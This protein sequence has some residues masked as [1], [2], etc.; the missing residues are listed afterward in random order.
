MIMIEEKVR[1]IAIVGMALRVPRANT[2]DEFWT[3]IV[4]G[5]DCLSRPDVGQQERAGTPGSQITDSA[6]VASKPL[7]DRMETFDA[8][9][10][11]ISEMEAKIMDP[12]HRL[13][14][15]CVW[16]AMEQS[17]VVPGDVEERTGVFASVES[18]YYPSNLA[19]KEDEIPA[20]R[21]PKRLGNVNDYIAL[22][23]SHALD[24]KGPSVTVL[25]TC[26][27]SL[28]AVN[29]AA[30][31]LRAGKCTT[32]LAGGA[33][34]E[35][36][37]RAGYRSGLDGMISVSGVIRPFDADADGMI[38]GDGAGVV[39][40]KMLDAAIRDGN[41]IQAVIRGT[42]FCNDGQP[43]DKLSFIAPTTSGQKRAIEEALNESAVDPSTIG[44]MECHGTATRLGD[45]V[46]IAS[47][48][49]VFAERT[50]DKGICAL[51]S[52]KANIGHLGPAAGV[53]SLI[54]TCLV[55]SKRVIPPLAN[56]RALNPN[57]RLED[58]PF[59]VPESATQW[60]GEG[61]PHR[62][63]VSAF[64]F[65]GSNAHVVVE[66]FLPSSHT[67]SSYSNAQEL[68]IVSAKTE[69]AFQRRLND[70]AIFCEQE[71]ETPTADF[72]H[73]LQV[74]RQT[75]AFRTHLAVDSETVG[76]LSDRLR[77]AKPTGTNVKQSRPVVFLFPGQGSQTVGMGQG[78]YENES[79]FRELFDYCADV[80]ARKLGFDLRNC[81]YRRNGI[82]EQDAKAALTDTSIAQPALFVVEYALARQLEHWGLVPTTMIGH[83][84]GELVSACLAGVFSLDEGLQLVAIRSRLMQKC[85]PGSMLAVSLP[86]DDLLEI[87]PEELDLAAVNSTKRNVVAGPVDEIEKFAAVLKSKKIISQ[88]LNTSH[89]FHSRMLDETLEEFRH[90]LQDFEFHP[91][92]KLT[93]SGV[94]GSPMTDEQAQDPNYWIEQRRQ[95]VRFSD[96]LNLFLNDDNPI[97]VEVGPGRTLSGFV[98]QNDSSHDTITCL[99]RSRQDS[100]SDAHLIALDSVGRAWSMGANIQWRKRSEEYPVSKLNLPTYPFQRYHYWQDVS[101]PKEASDHKYSLS[102]YEPGWVSKDLEKKSP[103]ELTSEWLIF[104]DDHGFA[105]E[106][107]VRLKDTGAHVTVVEVGDQFLKLSDGVYEILPGSKEDLFQVLSTIQLQDEEARLGVL[108]FWNMTGENVPESDVV[109]YQAAKMKG[110]HTLIALMQVARECHLLNRLDV[111]IYVDGLAQVDPSKDPIYPEKGVLLGPVRVST[112]EVTGLSIR[113][114]DI[115]GNPYEFSDSSLFDDIFREIRVDAEEPVV[116]LRHGGRYAEHLFELPQI[117]QCAPRFRYGGTAL[118]T[119]GVGGLGLKVAEELFQSMNARLVLTSR[120]VPPAPD[121]WTDYLDAESKIGRAM[122]VLCPL[123]EQGAEII[124]LKADASSPEDMER[125]VA[126]AEAEFGPI[127][128]VVHTAGILEDGPSLQK[129][130]Q[131]AERVFAAKVGSAYVID[132]IFADKPLDMLIHFSSQASLRPSKG[133]VDYCSANSVLDRLATRRQQQHPGLSCAVGWGAWRDAGMAWEYKAGDLS[134]TSLFRKKDLAEL[135]PE[136]HSTSHPLLESYRVF[137]DGDVLFS[138]SLVKGE[139]WIT[140]EHQIGGR[141]VVS[142]TTI[143]EMVRAGFVDFF[144]PSGAIELLDVTFVTQFA[145]DDVTDYELLFSREGDGYQVELRTRLNGEGPDWHVTSTAT[146]RETEDD[147]SLD[148]MIQKQLTQ[149]RDKQSLN[150]DDPALKRHGPRWNCGS[151]AVETEDGVAIKNV[152]SPEFAEEVVNYGLH[153]SIFDRSIHKLTEH[154]HGVLLPYSC[155]RIR[156]YAPMPAQ[157]LSFGYLRDSEHGHTHDLF[158]TD[159]DGNLIVELRT[160]MMRDIFHTAAGTED[161]LEYGPTIDH[162]MVLKTPG[163]FDSFEITALEQAPLAADEIRIQVKAAGLN[164]RDVLSALGQLPEDDPTHDMRGSECSGIVTEVG[165]AVKHL[166]TGDRVLALGKHCFSTNVVTAGHMA[167]LLPESLSFTDGA[168]IPVTFLTVDYALNEAARLKS[169]EKILIHAASGG[170]GLAAV[171]MAQHIGAEIFATAGHDFKREYLQDLGVE[172]VLDSRSLD[173]VDR[174]N[175]LTGGK[176]VDVVLNSLAGEFIPAG[177]SLLKPFGRFIELGKKDIYANAKMDLYPFRNNLSYFGID[178]GQ[179][180]THRPD[181]HLQM[182]ESLMQRFAAGQLCPSPVQVFSFDDL[183]KGFK[184]LARTQ[185]IGKVVFNIDQAMT[186]KDIAIQRFT[187]RFGTGIA[188]LD[189]I[190]VLRRLISSDE[191]PAQVLAAA[192]TLD[193]Q[194]RTAR[195]LVSANHPR[196]VETVYREPET[197]TEELLKNIFE[198]TLGI[199]PIGVDDEFIELGGDSITAVML[200]VSL[201]DTFDVHLP[202][203]ALLNQSTI[204]ILGKL[205]DDTLVPASA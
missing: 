141:S 71:P 192:R 171:Q 92:R 169:G 123:V 113:C 108:H 178:L 151:V 39:V 120:W 181:D 184:Y 205:V 139:H 8:R 79:V 191:T 105:D 43:N 82:S 152:L 172:H 117:A 68:L 69:S 190:K 78:L 27:S 72:A 10:F 95:P 160:Y 157:T 94:T 165:S 162:R 21:V 116:A 1:D 98:N 136:K 62:A 7:I 2:L 166:R 173:F 97:F 118:I 5:R 36:P 167:T 203:S 13:F 17:A 147:R 155:D 185:H 70:L 183:G 90:E 189:G 75:M 38:F 135:G 121:K 100:V 187:S 25:A 84:L 26:S 64:G 106:I 34:V 154:Y 127:H 41:Q 197:I 47:L 42:G 156:I 87:I 103:R 179:F 46:E 55:L 202:L 180:R 158:V 54:K 201:K 110:F 142:A 65:G 115:P 83:S 66:E 126:D 67:T 29:L 57:L 6:F 37:R 149:V 59:Y 146:I 129:T 193:T 14:L 137:P 45:P 44:F 186:P 144:S 12:T 128:G 51:G 4:S 143:I 31:S 168:S 96:G 52:V 204:S 91:P 81:V 122:R 159:L 86:L 107:L 198:T 23:V 58:T 80:L 85:L 93:I 119:G 30:Q 164:F 56:F 200:Q 153:P 111:Q 114:I 175:E 195:H 177:L 48:R 148:L 18:Y 40:L 74:G 99:F 33:R 140:V 61:E 53:V 170:V 60:N 132:T 49:E 63:A 32:A 150:W 89:A 11:G 194:T 35:L 76:D 24:L 133:Q 130:F 28:M 163:V 131:S 22:R 88:A 182:F 16:E 112:Q 9:F 176:G 101:Q 3:N 20:I 109:A 188:V 199:S 73:T 196:V 174:V 138:G 161:K 134:S 77:R 102:L 104:A 15:E 124:I 19:E 145:V 125:L 50:T